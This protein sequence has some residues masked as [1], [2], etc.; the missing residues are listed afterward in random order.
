MGTGAPLLRRGGFALLVALLGASALAAGACGLDVVSSGASPPAP[1]VDAGAETSAALPEAGVVIDAA[2]EAAADSGQFPCNTAACVDDIAADYTHTCA[3]IRGARPRCWGDN[4]DGQLGSGL[5][6]DGGPDLDASASPRLV[7]VTLPMDGVTVG[8]SPLAGY[9]YSCARTAAG[10]VTC[11]G[12]DDLGQRG[13]PDGGAV[14]LSVPTAVTAIGD[15]RDVQAGGGHTCAVHGDGGLTC[16]GYDNYGQLGHAPSAGNIERTPTLVTLRAAATRITTGD[17]HTCALLADGTVDCWGADGAGQL[18]RGAA[19]SIGVNATPVTVTGVSGVVDVAAG[20]AHT[21]A[22][23]SGGSVTCWGYDSNGQLG[24]GAPASGG[25]STTAASVV[26]P[27]GKNATAV[28]AG[29]LHSCALLTDGTVTCWG[30]NDKGQLG[31][32]VVSG[33]LVTPAESATPLTVTGVTGARAVTCGGHHTCAIIENSQAVCWGANDK[34][35]L[36]A[37]IAP[38]ALPRPTPLPVSF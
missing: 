28:C 15:A 38:D 1:A 13:R 20:Y 22:A 23:L 2:V 14:E 27:A 7:A 19:I 30:L 11:W 34:G 18:G 35:Q 33:G 17:S 37:G 32:G 9:A 10:D 29:Y 36:G 4:S 12:Q 6:P 8:G 26:L 5:V 3:A 31:S 25:F 21:C 24:R 16:W